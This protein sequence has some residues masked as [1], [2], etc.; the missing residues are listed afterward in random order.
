MNGRLRLE[1]LL[2]DV[3][4][5]VRRLG[6]RVI[7]GRIGTLDYLFAGNVCACGDAQDWDC[8]NRVRWREI[9]P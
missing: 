7:A 9:L 8:L 6:T 3:L 1:F 2:R 4:R 5:I